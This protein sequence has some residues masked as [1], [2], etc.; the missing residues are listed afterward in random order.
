MEEKS[1]LKTIIILIVLWVIAIVMYL[2]D[3]IGAIMGGKGNSYVWILFMGIVTIGTLL[4][5]RRKNKKLI[6]H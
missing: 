3:P 4:K 2:L 6:N 1:L 5:F